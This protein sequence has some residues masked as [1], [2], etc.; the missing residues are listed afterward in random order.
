[1]DRTTYLTLLRHAR[2]RVRR[3][4]EAEDLLQDALLIALEARRGDLSRVENRRWL[5]GVMRNRALLDG[6]SA[7]RR[8]RREAEFEAMAP[9]ASPPD[10]PSPPPV[11]TL[12]PA[13]RTTA[14]LALTGDTRAEIAWLQGLSD[15]ALR[16]RISEIRRRWS[17]G[18]AGTDGEALR[19]DLPFGLMRRALLGRVRGQRPA[20]GSH[21]PD[22]NLFV[23]SSR[24][25]GRRQQRSS[26]S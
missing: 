5:A 11:M 23:V 16:K 24:I 9:T 10:A 3:L 13:L 20:L 17:G 25:P 2:R 6:R 1:M 22:G 14:L 4:P 26:D 12:P 8:R 19:G 18:D 21:D 7:A 15:V